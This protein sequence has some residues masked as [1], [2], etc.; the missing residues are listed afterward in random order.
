M[1]NN[2]IADN[3][4]SSVDLLYLEH[5]SIFIFLWRFT[6]YFVLDNIYSWLLYFVRTWRF[7][8]VLFVLQSSACYIS[9]FRLVCMAQ[10]STFFEVVH[11]TKLH[12][13]FCFLC[14]TTQY[15]CVQVHL[16]KV[17]RTKWL[18]EI[19]IGKTVKHPTRP[20]STYTF[21]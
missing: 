10:A 17:S 4:L 3:D 19:V 7:I 1:Y 8:S 15:T 2:L 13:L 21:K 12:T 9:P 20:C 14:S 16:Y 6:P 11:S 18:F 5:N